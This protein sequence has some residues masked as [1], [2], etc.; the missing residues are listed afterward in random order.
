M[1]KRGIIRSDAPGRPRPARRTRPGAKD[2]R[3]YDLAARDA[4]LRTAQTRGRGVT[5]DQHRAA[6]IANLTAAMLAREIDDDEVALAHEGLASAHERSISRESATISRESATRKDTRPSTAEIARSATRVIPLIGPDGR[7]G[8]H[9]VFISEIWLR[10][11]RE[12]RFRATNLSEFKD[13]LLDANREGML[14]LARADMV[15]AMDRRQ[16]SESEIVDR[17]ASF[18]FVLDDS[19]TPGRT[20]GR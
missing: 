9:K 13:A 7:Y 11:S 2:R 15:G 8:P 4:A 16:V 1:K 18:H 6:A 10:L 3:A 17:G 5:A 19:M 12:P 20:T 14:D